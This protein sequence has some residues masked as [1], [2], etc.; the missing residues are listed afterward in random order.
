MALEEEFESEIP[1]RGSREDHDRQQAIDYIKSARQGLTLR[2]AGARSCAYGSRDPEGVDRTCNCSR[3]MTHRRGKRMSQA[4]R[5]RH[6]SRHRL[7]VGNDV[8]DAWDNVARRQERHRPD[9]A[10]RR[11]APSRRASPARCADFDADAV[12]V[13]ERR[14]ARWI[15]SSTTAS[16]PACRRC[17]DSGH[18]S[19]RRTMRSASA[20]RSAPASAA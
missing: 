8:D 13:A 12:P 9:H 19:R 2:I 14:R 1:G 11:V 15:R 16:P 4:S 5:R 20:S 18:R 6:R 10:F 17:Q 7:P 3:L